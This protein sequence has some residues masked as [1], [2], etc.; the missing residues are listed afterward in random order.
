[1]GGK[2]E[3]RKKRVAAYRRASLGSCVWNPQKAALSRSEEESNQDKDG[4]G[5]VGGG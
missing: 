1:M 4:S 3:E 5:G 2:C